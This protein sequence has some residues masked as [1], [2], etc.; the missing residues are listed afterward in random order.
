MQIVKSDFLK[1]VGTLFSG[2]FVAQLIGFGTTVILANFLYDADE[3]GQLEGLLKMATVLVAIA[4]LRY[5]V[6][7]VVEDDIHEAQNLTRLSL[8]LNTA[9]SVILLVVIL[10]LKNTIAGFFNIENSNTLLLLPL[11]VWSMSCTET[12]INWRN[13]SKEYKIIST[14]RLLTSATSAGYKLGHPFIELFKGNG[15]I[16]GHLLGQ[17]I[18]LIHITKKLPFAIFNTSADTLKSIALKYRS[19]A[20]FSSPA[21][22]LNILAT[23][24]PIFM[25][26]AFDGTTSA[27][28]FGNAYKLSYLPMSMLAMALGQVFFERISRIKKDKEAASQMAHW[29]FNA[30]F[31]AALFPVV[32]LVVWGDKI[33]PY[34]LGEQWTETGIYIQIT[35]LFYFAM[36]MTS[37][38]SSAFSTYKKLNQQ[39]VYNGIFL[40]S[41]FLAL[42]LGYT[43]GGST[44][45]ALAWFAMVGTI[46]RIA[47][48]N[49]F[50]FLFGKNLI[51]KTIFAI[52]ITGILIYLGFG[53][54]EGF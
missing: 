6:A 27:G 1:N 38:F 12:V 18:A 24:M 7:V 52:L 9:T 31:F 46:L 3:F 25:I 44:R 42:Y 22:L 49:Y 51:T 53:I 50:F 23:S 28:Y 43:I 26:L 2:S 29:L 19:F 36:F 41:T 10:L 35:I 21:A 5:E 37:S 20:V 14:N 45:V 13:R 47:V 17:L 8:L 4:G 39:L 16:Y 40:I 34:I 11:F 15:L 54:K 32:I 33:A 48:L 30:M